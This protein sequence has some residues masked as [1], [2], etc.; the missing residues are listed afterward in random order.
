MCGISGVIG[1]GS[2]LVSN[3]ILNEM[4]EKIVH[5]GPDDGG[6]F[7]DQ[8]LNV[9]F[10]HR[11][12]SIIDLSDDGHQPF[13]SENNELVLIFNGEIYNYLEVRDALSLLGVAFN[14]ETDTE[15]VL[16]AYE[17]WGEECVTRFN[18]MWAISILDRKNKSVFFS[19]D[20]F[21]VKPLYYLDTEDF[22]CFG[23]EI[24]QLIP[25]CKEA[26]ANIELV[27]N[28]IVS[29]VS[30]YDDRTFFEQI[31]LIKPSHNYKYCL[32][33]KTLIESRYF[34]LEVDAET[35]E[36][37]FSGSLLKFKDKFR[38]S[39]KLRLRSD[40][41][42]GSCLSGG[43]DSSAVCAVASEMLA[44][45]GRLT[46]IHA[47]STEK[48]SDESYYAKLVGDSCD[49][50]L[51]VIEPTINDFINNM[52]EVVYTQ[53]EPFGSPSIFMQYFV[54]E[55]AKEL[56][57][58]V[59][60]DG[61]GGD[62]T[63]LG[64]EKYYPAAYL[65]L[66]R[67]DGLTA[68]LKAV[69]SSA[70]NN[71]KMSLIWIS[72]YFIGSVFSTL[73]KVYLIR[74]S[75]FIKKDFRPK[76]KYFDK[77]SSKYLTSVFELQKY[78]IEHTNLPVLLRYED[79]NSMRHSIETRLP[80]IDYELLQLSLSVDTKNKIKDGWTKYLLRKSVEQLLPDEL[81]WRKDKLG[82]NAP[83]GNWVD[84]RSDEML[85]E[86]KKSELIK[87]TCDLDALANSYM[88]LDIRLKWRLYSVA[89]WERVYGITV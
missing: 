64:Y 74:K 65:D 66:F 81:V 33:R 61:Q 49:L 21:G 75:S 26:R 12:L 1:K 73:R 37:S 14:T 60:L 79:K 76:L 88:S 9:G 85:Q 34:N 30:D 20:R 70:R 47:K 80:F 68:S 43:M 56:G 5:R 23:S 59:M 54:M 69:L 36:D 52:E 78:E 45:D 6:T 15:V 32:E 35:S 31:K 28:F 72:K 8:E 42:V 44:D 82:F 89:L 55:R 24:K 71:H 3:S 38:Q 86:I 51:D 25:F 4:N 63:L 50:K 17:Y 10:G 87:K 46:A 18:G 16:K 2:N 48:I 83:E 40:V 19:R 13:I 62:E 39:I 27:T 53:E 29:G 57:C 7:T 11:R 22:F 67:R 84:S 77:L 58:K 41:K